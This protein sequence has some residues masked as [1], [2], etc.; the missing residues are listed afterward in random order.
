MSAP[1]PIHF[2]KSAIVASA[3]PGASSAGIARSSWWRRARIRRLS[4][5]LPGHDRGA[6]VAAA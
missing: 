1:A 6:A 5:G 2:S 3:R 4:A